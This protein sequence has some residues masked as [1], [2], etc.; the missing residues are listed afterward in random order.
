MCVSVTVHMLV[1]TDV[2]VCE[3]VNLVCEW[4]VLYVSDRVCTSIPLNVRCAVS[5]VVIIVPLFSGS[6][7]WCGVVKTRWVVVVVAGCCVRKG[8][9]LGVFSFPPPAALA[10]WIFTATFFGGPTL[11]TRWRISA[12]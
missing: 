11:Q 12:S 7:V 1:F 9:L 6:P 10:V 2:R 5:M 4:F 8:T 3:P